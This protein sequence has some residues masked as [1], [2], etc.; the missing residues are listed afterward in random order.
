[1]ALK[2]TDFFLYDDLHIS[3]AWQHVD[4]LRDQLIDLIMEHKRE[5]AETD[6]DSVFDLFLKPRAVASLEYMH[7]RETGT[8]TWETMTNHARKT[9]REVFDRWWQEINDT[10][11][12]SIYFYFW[13]R[14]CDQC[15]SDRVVRFTS[16]FTASEYIV[17]FYDGAEGPCSVAQVDLKAYLHHTPETRDRRAE[18]Y[19]Y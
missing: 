5:G 9:Y 19:N 18:Q 13:S 4:A 1:M 2:M 14:D 16:W 11:D 7:E 3:Q 10:I 8:L 12:N 17:S 15:E 6:V